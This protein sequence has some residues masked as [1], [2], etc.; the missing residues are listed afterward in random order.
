MTGNLGPQFDLDDDDL[1]YMRHVPLF[2]GTDADLKPGDRVQAKTHGVA[3]ATPHHRTAGV[4]SKD[5]PGGRIYEVKPLADDHWADR[6]KYSG[7]ETHFEVVSKTGFEV[8]KRVPKR[9]SPAVESAYQERSTQAME[10]W[11]QRTGRT[12]FDPVQQAWVRPS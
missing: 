3:Y 6:M 12:T 4:F 2:H 8:V 1:G 9:L 10:A 11:K 7:G 5:R